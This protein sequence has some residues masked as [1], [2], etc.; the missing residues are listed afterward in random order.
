VVDIITTDASPNNEEKGSVSKLE[1]ND[2]NSSSPTLLSS[3]LLPSNNS[4]AIE[5]PSSH[6]NLMPMRGDNCETLFLS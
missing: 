1:T 3:A 2:S 5:T 6:Q 4:N